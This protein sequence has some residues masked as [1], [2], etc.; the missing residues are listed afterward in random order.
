MK[1]LASS[2]LIITLLCATNTL[3]ADSTSKMYSFTGKDGTH[4][5]TDTK[6]SQN[7]AISYKS[8]SSSSYKNMSSL[9][10]PKANTSAFKQRRA[11]I[12]PIISNYAKKNTVSAQ[13]IEAIVR[14]ES[15][16]DHKAVSQTG[17]KGLMQLMPQTAKG[18]G[19]QN[20]F[21]AEENLRAG[22]KYFG[23]LYKQFHYN[24][25]LA[26]A[27]D[28]AGPTNVKKYGGIPPFPE[29]QQYIV[30]VLNQYNMLLKNN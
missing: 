26:L 18:L 3:H 5:L 19:V 20:S 24:P 11:W 27:A 4:W 23:N 30:K 2:M 28:N 22:I 14:V 16:Y 17:A 1:N 10:C 9:S 25:D 12:D 8:F 6:F 7:G 29:T 13:L 15:C 21:N